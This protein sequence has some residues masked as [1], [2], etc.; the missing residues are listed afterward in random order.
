VP[1]FAL[2]IGMLFM[3]ESPRWLMAHGRREEAREVLARM[4]PAASLD[5]EVCE[6]QHL[7]DVE[8]LDALRAGRRDLL[9]DLRQPWIRRIF[10]IGIGVACSM[11]ATGVNSVTYYGTQI[12]AGAGF[13]ERQAL[14][15]NIGNGVTSVLATLL[16][17]WILAR[18]GRRIMLATGLAGTTAALCLGGILS[19]LLQAS[20]LRGACLLGTTMLFLLFMQ[21]FV[22]PVA[23]VI[24]AEI[25]PLRIRGLGNGTAA[26]CLWLVNFSV[27]LLFPSLRATLGVGGAF[28]V[29][30]ALGGVGILFVLRTV[31]ETRGYSLEQIEEN[32]RTRY[33]TA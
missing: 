32:F 10:L 20:P 22:A 24:L 18:T 29:F 6:V 26:L 7:A 5:E 19:L 28:L 13:G 8:H 9:D 14:V 25:F 16:G 17:L 2:W 21:G 23:W 33:G 12:L 1:A 3:P 4:R 27:G 31:P 15:A 11:Q 30:A